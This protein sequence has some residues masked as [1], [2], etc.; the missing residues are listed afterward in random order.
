MAWWKKILRIAS[1]VVPEV[2]DNKKVTVG[3]QVITSAF[4]EASPEEAAA[5]LITTA[6]ERGSEEPKIRA[7]ALKVHDVIRNRY[8]DDPDF[9]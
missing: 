7:I 6:I 8:H 4:N 3:T 9:N 5:T 2:T 1:V